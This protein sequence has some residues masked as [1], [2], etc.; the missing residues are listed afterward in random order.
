MPNSGKTIFIIAGEPSGDARA[1]EL[2]RTL[3]KIN[4]NL[5]FEGLGGPKMESEGAK[6]LFDMTTISALGLGDVLRQY[7]KIRG[8]FYQALNHVWKN[9]PSAVILIDY[10]GFNIRFAKKIQKKI[11]VF[12]YVSPQIWAWGMRRIHTLKR[13]VNHMFVLFQF[14][15]EIYRK[16]GIPVTWVGHPLLDTV[17]PSKVKP[18]LKR[19][20]GI[21]ENKTV[22]SL[23][24]G[25]REAEVKRILPAMLESALL[26]Q[27]KIPNSIFLISESPNVSSDIY[28]AIIEQF[29]TLASPFAKKKI[30][31]RMHDV[32]AISDFSLI[33]SGTATLE[34]TILEIPYALLYKAARSTYWIGR[35]LVKVSHLGIANI[36]AGRTIIP[37][38]IQN[39]IDPKK[40]AAFALQ[41]LKKAGSRK[42]ILLDLKS[43]KSQLGPTG[44]SE[45]AAKKINSLL[46]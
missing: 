9:K 40:I 41:V 35:Q 29:P 24:S 34:A 38:F 17:K 22:I 3:K 13:V 21:S 42:Q 20:F 28:D 33:T 37:E 11:P 43:V 18:E 10:P 39:D 5:R 32:L 44:A 30:R 19:D 27:N 26:I 12:Y 31:G 7:F 14:E 36:I 46:L 4:P 8:I 1:Q 23:L 25:S 2:I 6:L 16:A 15:E 45:R